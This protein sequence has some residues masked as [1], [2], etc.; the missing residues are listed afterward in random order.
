MFK[1]IPS[2]AAVAIAFASLSVPAARADLITNGSFSQSTNGNG[3]INYNTNL[4]GWTL[5]KD[6]G[7]A[8]GY[9]FLFSYGTADTTGANGQFGNLK[10]WGPGDGA[11]NGLPASSPDGGNFVGID[12][13]FQVGA[14]QQTVT[15]L[16]AGKQYTVSFWWGAAQQYGFTGATTEQFQVSLGG[17]TLTTAV[18][19]DVSH[20][21]SGWQY[22][23]LTFT[24][25]A[26]TDLLSFVAL[27]SPTGVPPFALLDG[28]S[29][30]AATPAP[31]PAS[32]ALL[33]G[34][35]GAFAGFARWRRRRIAAAPSPEPTVDETV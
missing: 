13:A 1:L 31:E 30:N 27:G 22:T 28:V 5:T 35:L 7:G 20:G 9:G 12:G 19:N 4:T 8:N 26:S 25:D 17:Q 23:S 2:I 14:L 18:I 32:A 24:A 3:Q 10:L 34:G 33:A 15:G 29:M 11:N 21:F 6:A 16:T